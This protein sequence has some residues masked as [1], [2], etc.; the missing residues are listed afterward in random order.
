MGRITGIMRYPTEGRRDMQIA[1]VLQRLLFAKNQHQMESGKASG[2]S[3]RN[4]AR[5][6]S[7]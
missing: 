7:L 3:D 6:T 4:D 1:S 2:T 5:S